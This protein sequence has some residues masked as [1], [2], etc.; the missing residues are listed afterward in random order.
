MTGEMNPSQFQILREDLAAMRTEWNQRFDNL[1]TRETFLDERRRVDGRFTDAA[2]DVTTFRENVNKKVGELQREIASEAQARVAD[3][4]A[5]L[6]AQVKESAERDRVRRQ[7]AWQWLA[8]GVT[9][10]AGPI[11]SAL[12]SVAM[13]SQGVGGP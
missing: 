12:V 13:V 6:E 1:V 11:I 8:I 9:L 3:T 4:R 10:V 2:R 7:T 5:A